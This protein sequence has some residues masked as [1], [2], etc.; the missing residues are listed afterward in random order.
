MIVKIG[1]LIILFIS[2]F[3]YC[4]VT[5]CNHKWIILLDKELK[6]GYEQ[7]EKDKKNFNAEAETDDLLTFFSKTSITLIQC[8]KCGQFKSIIVS[9]PRE[10]N[11]WQ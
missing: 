9:N 1:L 2:V 8:E 4:Y 5:R 10:K 3:I 11:G 6:S 7:L